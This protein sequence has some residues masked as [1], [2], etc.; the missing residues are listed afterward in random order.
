MPRQSRSP[1][2]LAVLGL[3]EEQPLHGYVLRR[4]LAARLGPRWSVSY[5]SLYP[6]LRRLE[7]RGA[8]ERVADAGARRRRHVYRITDAG[9]REFVER[10][11]A[12]AG[13]A[14]DRDEQ[15]FAMRLAFFAHLPAERR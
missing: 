15:R 4:R 6:T 1:L 5:G 13:D 7:R 14:R 12:E 2:E 3:L 8:I 10:L 9:A 11:A